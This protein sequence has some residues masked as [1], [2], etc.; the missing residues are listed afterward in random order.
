MVSDR[1]VVGANILGSHCDDNCCGTRASSVPGYGVTVPTER[2]SPEPDIWL[3][4]A[5]QAAWRAYIETVG[6]LTAALDA[7]LSATGL[8]LGDYQVLVYLSEVEQR[9]MR[10][11]DLAEALRLS[12]SGLTRRLDGLVRDGLVRREGS[13][14]DR[15]VMLAVLTD[16]GWERLRAVAPIHVASVRRRIFDHLDDAQVAALASTFRSIAAGLRTDADTT[17]PA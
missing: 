13:P 17:P 15:R 14:D 12:P 16:A 2:P 11:C 8:N 3:D 6:D 4:D 10:M 9:R 1:V 7:D 5:Q